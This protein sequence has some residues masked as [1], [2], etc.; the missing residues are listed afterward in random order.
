MR[1]AGRDDVVSRW[2]RPVGCL[3]ISGVEQRVAGDRAPTSAGPP[4]AMLMCVNVYY[5][6]YTMTLV[7]AGPAQVEHADDP[8]NRAIG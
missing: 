8:L 2:K 5:V 1:R 6:K 3:C 4:S 7:S